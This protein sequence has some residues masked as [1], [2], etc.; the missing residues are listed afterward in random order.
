M[1]ERYLI[2][3][4]MWLVPKCRVRKPTFNQVEEPFIEVNGCVFEKVACHKIKFSVSKISFFQIVESCGNPSKES[5][6]ISLRLF[7]LDSG[8][9]AK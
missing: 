7:G 4:A 5:I 3:L 6:P 1:N 9:L 2:Y 8:N